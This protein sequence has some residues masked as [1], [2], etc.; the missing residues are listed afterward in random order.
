MTIKC[1]KDGR[2]WS[3]FDSEYDICL[4]G[5]TKKDA[6][7]NIMRAKASLRELEANPTKNSRHNRAEKIKV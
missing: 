5:E 4:S 2:V 7:E 1:E 6:L 3:A